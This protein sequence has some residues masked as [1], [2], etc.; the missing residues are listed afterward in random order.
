MNAR[1]WTAVFAVAV[2]GPAF[3]LGAATYNSQ[4]GFAAPAEIDFATGP[5]HPPSQITSGCDAPALNP[6]QSIVPTDAGKPA[7]LAYGCGGGGASAAFATGHSH[8]TKRLTVTPVFTLPEGWS[9]GIGA[10]A[11]SGECSSGEVALSS[12]TA[13][14]LSPDTSYVYCLS[15]T[16]AL[17]F[18]SF[19]VS[20][21]R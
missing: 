8:S 14:V 11:P 19:L 6:T 9:L 3:V 10:V 18:S 16:N 7:T 4:P 21:T 15:A 12:G 2:L 5:S 20:W 13:L 1:A 17:S